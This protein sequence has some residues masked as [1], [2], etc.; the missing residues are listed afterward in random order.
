MR[1]ELLESKRV[2]NREL[3]GFKGDRSAA[4]GVERS[5]SGLRPRVGHIGRTLAT[6]L[7]LVLS[8]I[9]IGANNVGLRVFVSCRYASIV[10]YTYLDSS[11]IHAKKQRGSHARELRRR[12]PQAC[13]RPFIGHLRRGSFVILCTWIVRYGQPL[14]APPTRC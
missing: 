14:I 4:L 11:L 2:K 1:F 12:I 7:T 3:K 10:A 9:V 5:H 8:H 13:G 6:L